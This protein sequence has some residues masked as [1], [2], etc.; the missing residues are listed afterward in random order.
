MNIALIRPAVITRQNARAP[1]ATAPLGLAYIAAVLIESG[2]HVHVVD[3]LGEALDQFQEV[4]GVP[5]TLQHGLNNEQIVAS[6]SEDVDLIGVSAMFSLEWPF[7]RTLIN[8]IHE[9]FPSVSIVIGGEHITACAEYVLS[10][11]PAIRY[12]VL[13]EGEDTI[14]ELADALALGKDV[15]EVE[16]LIYRCNNGIMRTQPRK[17][18]RDVDR[19]PRP[20][21]HLIPIRSYSDKGVT[22]GVNIGRSMPLLASRGCPYECTFCSNPQMWGTTWKARSPENVLDEMKYYI[23]EYDAQNFNFYD[24]TAIVKKDWIVKL[25]NLIIENNLNITWQLPS[26]TRS[27]VIDDEVTCLLY[28]SGCRYVIYAPESGSKEILKMIK[29]KVKTE[30]MLA[31][32][33]SAVQNGL[34]IKVN[35]LIGFPGEKYSHVAETFKFISQLAITGVHDLSVSYYSPYPGSEIFTNLQEKGI[36]SLS[37]EYFYRLSEYTDSG[38]ATSYTEHM[39]GKALRFFSIFGMGIFYAIQFAARPWRFVKFCRSMIEKK[40]NSR[41]AQALIRIGEKKR[42]YK[43]LLRLRKSDLAAKTLPSTNSLLSAGKK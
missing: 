9:R 23:H 16:G 40:P 12:C 4:P 35:I 31:S 28:N 43:K 1:D 13:G 41:L 5:G 24:L 20:A 8:M 38:E 18:I 21:W 17:R 7:I 10:D 27:E 15:Q 32:I 19:L 39:S 2:H 29:K 37:D 34:N 3:G 11:C 6:I 14:A 36:V 25:A 42:A 33:K 30:R 26:G 22:N